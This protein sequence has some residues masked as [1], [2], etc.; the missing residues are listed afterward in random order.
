MFLTPLW[1]IVQTGKQQF[2]NVFTFLGV[3]YIQQDFGADQ[4]KLSAFLL[5]TKSKERLRE[6][7]ERGK[8]PTSTC[9]G[10]SQMP[11]YIRMAGQ[12]EPSVTQKQILLMK[13]RNYWTAKKVKF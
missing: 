7:T 3:K 5:S 12:F 1:A 4:K 11:P 13:L 6:S 2:L 10:S 9:M 8:V